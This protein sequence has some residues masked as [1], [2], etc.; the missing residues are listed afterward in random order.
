MRV[1]WATLGSQ[2]KI[3]FFSATPLIMITVPGNPPDHHIQVFRYIF[4][5]KEVFILKGKMDDRK[6]KPMLKHLE[7]RYEEKERIKH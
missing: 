5:F 3:T 4:I 6:C 1:P 7:S 2:P